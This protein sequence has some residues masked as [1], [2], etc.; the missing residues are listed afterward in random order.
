MPRSY[1]VVSSLV[2]LWLFW[3]GQA[4]HALIGAVIPVFNAGALKDVFSETTEPL[5]ITVTALIGVVVT[6]YMVEILQLETIVWNPIDLLPIIQAHYGNSPGARAGVFFASI[7]LVLSQLAITV[8]LNSV[9]CGMDM[10]GL[11]PRWINIRRGGYIMI[12]VGILVQPWTLVA[13]AERFLTVL[14]GFGIFMAPFT[15]VMLADYLVIRKQKLRLPD[16]YRGDASSI[17]WFSNGFNWRG[18]VAFGLGCVFLFPGLIA[19]GGGYA[20]AQ[21]W[22]R[23]FNLTT[24]LGT[25]F[26][27]VIMVGINWAWP[28]A[29][30][31][32][33]APFW[34][35]AEGESVE[36]EGAEA[37]EKTSEEKVLV[38]EV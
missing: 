10:A 7:G 29:G 37:E 23:L 34:V 20:I 5:F 38:Q 24:I 35:D 22:L 33:D 17:Y 31:G 25:V 19:T 1:Y 11:A 27:F 15:G 14:S 16:L 21:G 13:S 12:C 36:E 8:V 28:P 18:F 32:E 26:S 9:S 6:S 4:V 3:G 2:C 30:L